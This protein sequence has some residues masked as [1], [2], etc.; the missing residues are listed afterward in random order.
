MFSNKKKKPRGG[1]QALKNNGRTTFWEDEEKN[2]EDV[3]KDGKRM[4][5]RENEGKTYYHKN[6]GERN[7]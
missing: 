5:T 1:P 4:M 3:D 2:K 6:L 7:K